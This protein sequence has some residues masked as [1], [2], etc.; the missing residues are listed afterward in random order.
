M[1]EE[2]LEVLP[3][4]LVDLGTF[5]EDLAVLVVFVAFEEEEGLEDEVF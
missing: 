2:L 4:F 5:E 1:L 3:T